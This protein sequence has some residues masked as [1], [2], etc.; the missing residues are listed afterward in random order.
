MLPTRLPMPPTTT[1]AT[2]MMSGATHIPGVSWVQVA[3]NTPAS[4]ARA[5]EIAQVARFIRWGSIPEM[6]A[7]FR[8]I[9][10]ARSARPRRVQRTNTRSPAS[11]IQLTTVAARILWEA[12]TPS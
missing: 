8:S 12:N 7:P 11:T 9:E 6:T 1:T 10:T 4:A 2:A 5:P 3:K